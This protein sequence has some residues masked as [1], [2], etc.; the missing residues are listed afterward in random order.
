MAEKITRVSVWSARLRWTHGTLAISTLL[1]LVTGWLSTKDANLSETARGYHYLAAYAFLFALAFRAYLLFAGTKSER[2]NACLPVKNWREI[3]SQHTRFY[4]SAGRSELNGW[5]AH[6][7]FWGPI[8]LIFFGLGFLLIITGFAIG[9]LFIPGVSLTGIHAVAAGV[10]LVLTV[11]HIVAVILHDARTE[12]TSI[13]AIVSGNRYF[14]REE[15]QAS[16]PVEYKVDFPV[17]PSRRKE[18]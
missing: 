16:G 9:N 5:F 11:A 15:N 6:N 17:M 2:V 7:P 18:G 8:Y 3:L 1:L 14:Q 12:A 10:V 13:S 4:L